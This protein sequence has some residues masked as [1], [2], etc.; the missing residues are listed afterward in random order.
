MDH[1]SC[2]DDSFMN[3][4]SVAE[5]RVPREKHFGFSPLV[6][7]SPRYYIS[8]SNCVMDLTPSEDIANATATSGRTGFVAARTI[9]MN[10][11]AAGVFFRNLLLRRAAA[12]FTDLSIARRGRDICSDLDI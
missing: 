11:E 1:K 3:P 8:H 9:E 10:T 2:G 7:S 5:I 6:V 4:S 12:N